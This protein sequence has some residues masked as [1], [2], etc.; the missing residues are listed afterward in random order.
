M[1]N[2]LDLTTAEPRLAVVSSAFNLAKRQA[3]SIG[4][5]F[6][7]DRPNGIGAETDQMTKVS[8]RMATHPRRSKRNPVEGNVNDHM[9]DVNAN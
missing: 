7:D 4:D 1:E 8:A 2:T 6:R 9:A 3:P 5:R